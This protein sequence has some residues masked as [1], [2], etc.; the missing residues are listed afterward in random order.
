MSAV[1]LKPS[2]SRVTE[3]GAEL[4]MDRRTFSQA[5]AGTIA[6]ACGL[7]FGSNLTAEESRPAT[8]SSAPFDLSIM[9]WT[10]FRGLPFAQRLEKVAEAGFHN[11]ELV[12]EYAK[13]TEDDFQL[14]KAKRR[15]LNLRFDCTAGLKHG[16]SVPGDRQLLLA[17]LRDA[18]PVMEKLD[19]PAMIMMSGNRVPGMPRELQHESCIETLKAAAGMVE[20]QTINGQPVRLLLETIDPEENPQYYLTQIAEALEV[21]ETVNHPQVQLLYDLY[22]EQISA[23]NLIAKLEKSIRHL[24]LVHIADVPGRHEPGTGEINYVNIFR[25]LAELNFT[26]MVAMEFLPTGD[27]VSQLRSAR[28]MALRTAGEALRK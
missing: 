10:V 21:V 18:L 17:E 24:A 22:H 8:R 16:V 15:E 20:G 5:L 14:A 11:V 7:G 3:D 26:G 19:C 25:K 4:N 1:V 6:G 13:W 9:L 23:G 12:G 27:P 28:E 2:G